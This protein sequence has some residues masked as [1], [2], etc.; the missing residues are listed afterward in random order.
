MAIL[1]ETYDAALAPHCPLGPL[2]LAAEV[3]VDAVSANFAIQ[4]MS[5]G[6]HY[7]EGS[8]DLTSYI[9]NPEVWD[10]TGG[11]IEVP[12]GVG[13]GVEVDE[14][15]VRKAAMGDDGK[16]VRSW[17]SPHFRGVGGELREW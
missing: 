14:E 16:G 12:K 15:A 13:L 6:I 11:T 9:K 17:R 5:L 8:A 7:N 3:Q 1:A 4:E 2:S 10:V